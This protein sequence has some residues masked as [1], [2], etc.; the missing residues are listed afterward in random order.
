MVA[1]EAKARWEAGELSER[2]TV[3]LFQWLINTGQVWFLPEQ[4]GLAANNLIESGHCTLPG[5]QAFGRLRPGGCR[6]G[7]CSI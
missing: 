2:E 1:N 3:E 6:G 4:Y 5:Q 7:S